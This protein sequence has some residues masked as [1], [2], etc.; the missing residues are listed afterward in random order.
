MKEFTYKITDQAGIHARPAGYLVKIAEKY[1]SDIKICL[2]EEKCAD[3]KG[4]FSIMKLGI[5]CG[6]EIT[7]KITGEDETQAFEEMSSFLKESL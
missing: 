5:K 7:V 6:D 1:K 4:L 2:G 3:A